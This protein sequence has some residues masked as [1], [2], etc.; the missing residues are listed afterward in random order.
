MRRGNMRISE[1]I[2][3]LEIIKQLSGD[4]EIGISI[5]GEGNEFKHIHEV[6]IADKDE[7]FEAGDLT[8]FKVVIFPV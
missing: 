7:E 3:A 1:L 6:S 2:R 8:K 4:S 5:D